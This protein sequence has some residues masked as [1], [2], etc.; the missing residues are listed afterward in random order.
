MAASP[1]GSVD[2][3]FVSEPDEALMCLICMEVAKEPWQHAKC[4]RLF[5]K[6]CLESYGS[7]K[8]CPTCRAARPS[9]FEDNRS[10]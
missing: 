6:R 4:G 8:P 5:C 9:Y 10:E 3:Q 2:Y 1:A 7:S